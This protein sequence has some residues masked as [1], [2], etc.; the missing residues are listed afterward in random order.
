MT[1]KGVNISKIA[2]SGL[3]GAALGIG[4]YFLYESLDEDVKEAIKLKIKR[5]TVQFLRQVLSLE[6]LEELSLRKEL[7]GELRKE[8]AESSK[9]EEG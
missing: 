3:I 9:G 4:A 8:L 2:I 1:K 5:S 7:K 6:E